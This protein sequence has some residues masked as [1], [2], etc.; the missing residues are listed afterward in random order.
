MSKSSAGN[1][2][3]MAALSDYRQRIIENSFQ[4]RMATVAMS[5]N[6]LDIEAEACSSGTSLNRRSL[7][8]D[9]VTL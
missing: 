6:N 2:V 8:K 7:D 4:D 5:H 3:G 1:V 9:Y